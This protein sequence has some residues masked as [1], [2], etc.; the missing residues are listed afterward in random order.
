MKTVAEYK[1]SLITLSVGYNY[2]IF[3]RLCEIEKN[4]TKKR[5][6]VSR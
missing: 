4:S 5:E 3:G 1:L 2:Q 6:K